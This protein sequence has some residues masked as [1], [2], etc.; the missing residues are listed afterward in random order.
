MKKKLIIIISLVVIIIVGMI[1]FILIQ[2]GNS[3][4]YKEDLKKQEEI[5]ERYKKISEKINSIIDDIIKEIDKVVNKDIGED[6]AKIDE[7]KKKKEEILQFSITINDK[8]ITDLNKLKEENQN[9][10]NSLKKID[11]S[12][13]DLKDEE[14]DDY[15]INEENQI[16]VIAKEI[17]KLIEEINILATKQENI[18]CENQLLNGDFSCYAGVYK[19]SGKGM[20][21]DTKANLEIDKDGVFYLKY[22]PDREVSKTY[23]KKIEKKK[24]GSYYIY[25]EVDNRASAFYLFPSGT[26]LGSERSPYGMEKTDKTKD[27]ICWY[28]EIG[29]CC[30]SILQKD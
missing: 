25:T 20:A 14:I 23:F 26:S 22:E 19:D 30:F 3:T 13:I 2:S 8:K 1:A 11:K 4:N 12:L 27:R 16:N 28:D 10:E 15:T 18:K 29:N 9:L 17:K 21:G 24:N 6:T 7:L 5:N